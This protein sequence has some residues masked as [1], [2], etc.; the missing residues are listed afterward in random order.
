MIT[1]IYCDEILKEDEDRICKCCLE[2]G[3][4]ED[5]CIEEDEYQRNGFQN[6]AHFWSWKLG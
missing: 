3:V 2:S 4:D 6:K 5:D 1:C